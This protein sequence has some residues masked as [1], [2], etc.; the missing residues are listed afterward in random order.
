VEPGDIVMVRA[1]FT[2]LTA[3]AFFVMI[4]CCSIMLLPVSLHTNSLTFYAYM[5][6]NNSKMSS[7]CEYCRDALLPH[8]WPLFQ[9]VLSWHMKAAT[10]C[11]FSRQEFVGG[12]QSLG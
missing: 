11:E 7:R 1:Y 8:F 6:H 10:M 3:I 12:L 2:K 5:F 9:L 4:S